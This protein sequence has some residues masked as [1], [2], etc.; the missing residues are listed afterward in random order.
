[1]GAPVLGSSPRPPKGA[2]TPVDIGLFL[3]GAAAGGIADAVTNW[4]GFT[5]PYVCAT[6][7]GSLVLGLKKLLWDA[8]RRA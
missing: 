4:A 5:E 6:L 3:V 1:M 2:E 8:T 7:T